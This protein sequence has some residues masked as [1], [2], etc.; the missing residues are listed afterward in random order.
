[1]DNKLGRIIKDGRIIKGMSQTDLAKITGVDT[2]TISLIERGVRKKPNIDTLLKLAKVLNIKDISLLILA[3]YTQKEVSELLFDIK[4]EDYEYSFEFKIKGH[5]KLSA[6][7]LDEAKIL[8]EDDLHKF[9][10]IKNL[11]SENLEVTCDD[12][13]VDITIKQ[14]I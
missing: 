12:C 6:I 13:N 10:S 7:D 5:G 2:K 14:E 3:G 9:L 8:I 4:E 11:K 1:M